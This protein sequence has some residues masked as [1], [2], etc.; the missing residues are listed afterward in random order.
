MHVY[1]IPQNSSILSTYS[2]SK[3]LQIFDNPNQILKQLFTRPLCRHQSI[4]TDFKHERIILQA[5]KD[6][7]TAGDGGKNN[8]HCSMQNFNLE[9]DFSFSFLKLRKKGAIQRKRKKPERKRETVHRVCNYIV[10]IVKTEYENA[11]WRMEQITS[12]V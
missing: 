7:K 9:Y 1:V 2:H 5:D 6:I 4:K 3:H 8:T 11:R 12:L 10:Y